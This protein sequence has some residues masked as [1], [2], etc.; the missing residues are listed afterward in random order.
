MRKEQ[1]KL[2][3]L[4]ERP[5]ARNDSTSELDVVIEVRSNQS[6]DG[7]DRKKALNL[8]L[9]IDR[10]GSMRGDKLETAKKSCIDIYK[11][12]DEKDLFTVVVFD[13]EA[14]VVVN[15]QVPKDQSSRK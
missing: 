6:T 7:L 4:T 14:E 9:V 1:I 3:I 8:C 2:D 15:P 13:D 5:I 12:L 11:Q 10:S